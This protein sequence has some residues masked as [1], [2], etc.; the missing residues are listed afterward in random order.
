MAASHFSTESRL[1]SMIVP[2]LTE[3]C[4]RH[5]RHFQIPRVSRKIG[6]I[7]PHPLRGQK[8]PLGQRT[9]ARYRRATPGLANSTIASIKVF[10]I[11]VSSF[12]GLDYMVSVGV[13]SI[14]LP[15]FFHVT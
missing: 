5:P 14:L 3:N 15:G 4:F 1:S 11:N 8:T 6:F 12:M 10:G 13:S 9:R 2:T 7:S